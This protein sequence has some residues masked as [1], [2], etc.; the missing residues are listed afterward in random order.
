L[1]PTRREFGTLNA[2]DCF[3]SQPSGRNTV[4]KFKLLGAATKKAAAV[5]TMAAADRAPSQQLDR[6]S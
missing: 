3:P 1:N 2:A 4:T 6:A 5:L